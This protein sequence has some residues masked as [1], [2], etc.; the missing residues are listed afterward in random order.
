MLHL[1]TISQHI[2]SQK[3]YAYS[4]EK[5]DFNTQNLYGNNDKK[6]NT[7]FCFQVLEC[8]CECKCAVF[9]SAG[10]H[11]LYFIVICHVV[12]INRSVC[13]FPT[14]TQ[15]QLIGCLLA[16]RETVKMTL[17]QNRLNDRLSRNYFS[18]NGFR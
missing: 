4:S 6:V 1:A 12:Y 16:R 18:E 11:R 8:T 13:Y 3:L 17:L 10:C 14:R 15:V 2:Y 5:N 7:K 9:T